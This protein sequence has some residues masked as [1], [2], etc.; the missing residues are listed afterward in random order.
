M[1]ISFEIL[2]RWIVNVHNVPLLPF[3]YSS[4]ILLQNSSPRLKASDQVTAENVG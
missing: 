1:H 2:V 3:T 4:Y